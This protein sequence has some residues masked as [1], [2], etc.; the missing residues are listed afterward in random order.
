MTS[1]DGQ[2]ALARLAERAPRA[3]ALLS[4]APARLAAAAARVLD[5]SDF[6]AATLHSDERLL[7]MLLERAAHDLAGPLPLAA[8]QS[9]D[10]NDEA[11][12]MSALRRWRHAEL[13]R[14]AWR[15]LAG[16]ASLPDTLTD[17]SNAADLAL[18]SA[19][20]I[21][22]AALAG[23]YGAPLATDGSTQPLL[24]VAMGKLGGQELNFS[25]DI[26]LVFLYA[27]HGETA[28][29]QPIAYEDF[30]TRLG[31]SLIRSVDAATADGRAWRVDMRLRPFGASAP[32]VASAAAFEDYL[33]CHGRDW[34]R[35]AWIKARAV[36]DPQGFEAVFRS[37]VQPFVYRRYLDF[38]VFEALREMKALISREVA[39]RELNDNIKLGYGG[40]REIEFI[41]QSMQL[42][43]GGSERRLQSASL[44][45]TLP[46]LAG[47]K[48]LPEQTGVFDEA[49]GTIADG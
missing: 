49:P 3:A 46:R 34:E 38:G 31:Q 22:M 37:G 35:Y 12:F 24:I 10:A 6:V 23:R 21:A 13:T 2:Q 28:G 20:D 43:R 26:D 14:I 47:A 9:G 4:A 11:G 29:A 19:H 25:S 1:A 27:A 42:V 33:E 30:Y 44:L 45:Q 41:V 40:I 8:F 32:L 15:D 7:P 39:R 18:P 5:A 48:L 36:T 17:L 16:W